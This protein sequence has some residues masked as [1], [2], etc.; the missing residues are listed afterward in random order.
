MTLVVVGTVAFDSVSG[1]HGSM[2]RMLGGSATYFSLAA[3]YFTDVR[4]VGVVGEDFEDHHHEVLIK[5]GVC[6]EGIERAPGKSFFWAGEYSANMNERQTLDTQLNVLATFDPKLPE[7]YRQSPY[8]FLGNIDP[9]LQYRVAGQMESPRLI[10]GDTMNFWIEGKRADLDKMLQKIHVLLINDSEARQLSGEYNLLKAAR[11]IQL[12]GPE[13][14]VIK[15]GDN[16][17]TMLQK[18]DIF[19]VPALPL[20]EVLDP[21]G[22]GDSFAGGFMGYLASRSV[23]ASVPDPQAFRRAMVY[24]SVMGSFAVEKFGIERLLHLTREQIEA[25]LGEFQR[26]TQFD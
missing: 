6:T 22:A 9:E 20:E 14:V 13:T 17:A 10:A 1:P 11:A 25:R 5:R 7:H 15:R 4:V 23:S 8:L 26:L 18:A 2:E 16:G 24:G 21:T 12:M 3:S 19:S